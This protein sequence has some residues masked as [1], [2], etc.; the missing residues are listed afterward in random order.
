MSKQP[1]TGWQILQSLW[2]TLVGI[3]RLDKV[4][5]EAKEFLGHPVKRILAVFFGLA[6]IILAIRGN[7]KVEDIACPSVLYLV[8]MLLVAEVVNVVLRRYSKKP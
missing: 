7:L 1:K 6:L 3:F 8:A 4:L 2:N 5:K